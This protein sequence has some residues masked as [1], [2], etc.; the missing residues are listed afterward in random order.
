L[1]FVVLYLFNHLSFLANE[2]CIYNVT[3]NCCCVI[4]LDFYINAHTNYFFALLIVE[5]SISFSGEICIGLI[6]VTV[7]VTFFLVLELFHFDIS[8]ILLYVILPHSSSILRSAS[9]R[10]PTVASATARLDDNGLSD[11]Q[12]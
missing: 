1:I 2:S 8:V 4:H 5:S 6:V 9:A 7:G 12:R 11:Q 3:A 10:E